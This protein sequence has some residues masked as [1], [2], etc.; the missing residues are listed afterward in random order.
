MTVAIKFRLDLR[1]RDE[2]IQLFSERFIQ[3]VIFKITRIP[4]VYVDPVTGNHFRRQETA[5]ETRSVWRDY[6][7][8]QKLYV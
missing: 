2:T 1:W 5:S 7:S 3:L 8:R 4:I 6:E